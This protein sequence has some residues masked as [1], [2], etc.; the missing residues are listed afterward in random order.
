M[1]Q[2][3]V[4]QS[5]RVCVMNRVPTIGKVVVYLPQYSPQKEQ[6]SFGGADPTISRCKVRI[7][8]RRNLSR[9]VEPERLSEWRATD[10]SRRQR[11]RWSR[12]C[13]QR[14]IESRRVNGQE[15]RS[16]KQRIHTWGGQWWGHASSREEKP[17]KG[18]P[19]GRRG[20]WIISGY[21][22]R[23][24]NRMEAHPKQGS[25]LVE[26]CFQ[27]SGV[28]REIL[29]NLNILKGVMIVVFWMSLEAIELDNIPS[30]RPTWK[31]QSRP[32]SWR[33]NHQY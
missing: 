9:K 10:Y 5:R 20:P 2:Q 6:R 4:W 24:R 33:W 32:I 15:T 23:R 11:L 14:Q 27:C 26:K 18:C 8:L 30:E 17:P 31:T 12:V 13:T 16:W 25:S 19:R 7:P 28:Q 22:P 1:S 29:R 21:H 3:F